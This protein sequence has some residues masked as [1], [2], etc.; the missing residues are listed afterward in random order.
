METVCKNFEHNGLQ[1]NF[2]FHQGKPNYFC[3]QKGFGNLYGYIHKILE[4]T[5]SFFRKDK[6]CNQ[7]E[8]LIK[9]ETSHSN[10]MACQMAEM[11]IR[12]KRNNY[13][14]NDTNT[15]AC[16]VPVWFWDIALYKPESLWH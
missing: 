6:R 16:E 3:T 14:R 5:P 2:K 8:E 9:P 7:P 12:G 15:I 13:K 10:N 4:G 11:A 1:Y